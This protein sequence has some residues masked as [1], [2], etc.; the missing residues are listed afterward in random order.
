VADATLQILGLGTSAVPLDY[1]VS[2]PQILDLIAVKGVFDGSSAASAFVAVVQIIS[3]AG[4]VMATSTSPSIAAG[5]S[6]TVTFAP[7]LRDAAASAAGGGI[8]FDTFPQSGDWLYVQT[9]DGT[10]APSGIPLHLY[11]SST[12]AVGIRLESDNGEIDIQAFGNQLALS[13]AGVLSMT[14]SVSM[15]S[16][17]GAFWSMAVADDIRIDVGNGMSVQLDSVG[18]MFSVLDHLGAPIFEVRE[19]G[20]L[21]GK[22]GQTLTFDL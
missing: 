11:D 12:A 10:A 3:P 1:A 19:D 21:H 13:S 9:T 2:G 20:S 5:S 4:E 14:S 7:F 6:A 17:V 16:A 8:K 15:T 18:T 22:T